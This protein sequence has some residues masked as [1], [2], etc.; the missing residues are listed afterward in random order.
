MGNKRKM[1]LLEWIT[2]GEVGISSKTMWAAIMGT[3]PLGH[4]K[5]WDFDVPHD[6]DDFRRCL[7]LVNKCQL[8]KKDLQ[9]VKNSVP[10]FAPFIDN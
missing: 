1:T 6:G 8:G 9:K 5:G 2:T 10:W 7:E 3:F 4:G